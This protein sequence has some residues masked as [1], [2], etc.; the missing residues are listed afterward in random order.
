GW[1]ALFHM[2]LAAAGGYL[3][4]REM[5]LVP[6]A[7]AVGAGAFSFNGFL[8]VWLAYPNVSQS[9]LCWLPLILFLWERGSK[10]YGRRWLAGCGAALGLAMLGGHPQM[11]LY[12]W[13][14]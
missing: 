11:A 1:S 3:F 7:A 13:T 14:A 6:A 10:P 8:I 4:F 5:K 2:T 9:T 12:L